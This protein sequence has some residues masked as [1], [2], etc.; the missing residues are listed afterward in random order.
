MTDDE[1]IPPYATDYCSVTTAS[2]EPRLYWGYENGVLVD[3]TQA[4]NW[5][6]ETGLPIT[7]DERLPK[8]S[9]IP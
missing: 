1:I 4:V 2:L 6:I 5:N 8:I 9:L 7:I 3:I